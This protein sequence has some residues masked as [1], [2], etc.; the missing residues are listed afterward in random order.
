MGSGSPTSL[1]SDTEAGCRVPG[2]STLAEGEV[3]TFWNDSLEPGGPRRVR[4]PQPHSHP[5]RSFQN[6]LPLLSCLGKGL[7]TMFGWLCDTAV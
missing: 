3:G 7:V 6:L 5:R 1:V 2:H 4:S